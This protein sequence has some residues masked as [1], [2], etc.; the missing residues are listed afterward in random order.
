MGK[1]LEKREN[2]WDQ[3]LQKIFPA[4]LHTGKYTPLQHIC[5]T[6]TI[7]ITT[8]PPHYTHLHHTCHIPNHLPHCTHIY[9]THTINHTCPRH[10][11]PFIQHTIY[12]SPTPKIHAYHR[13]YSTTHLHYTY[14]IHCAYCTH[15]ICLTPHIYYIPTPTLHIQE[16]CIYHTHIPSPHIDSTAHIYH[17]HIPYTSCIHHP[18]TLTY[19]LFPPDSE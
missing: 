19:S 3:I 9:T 12:H 18:Y 13:P 2:E 11:H 6:Y 15:T 4:V 8:P 7:H 10:K 17:I 5:N 16:T 1:S 14:H